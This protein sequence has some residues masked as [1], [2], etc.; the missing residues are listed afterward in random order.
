MQAHRHRQ[1]EAAVLVRIAVLLEELTKKTDA[2]IQARRKRDQAILW[3]NTFWDV[4][5]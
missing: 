3:N 2:G 5:I 1:I 4:S